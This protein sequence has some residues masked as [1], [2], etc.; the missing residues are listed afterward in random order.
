MTNEASAT[1]SG[2]AKAKVFIS[3]S[4]T[5]L[6]FAKRLD[7]TLNERGFE[8]FIDLSGIAPSELW[9]KRLKEL[10]TQADT[11]IFVLSPEAVDSK[12]CKEEV[13]YAGFPQ[14]ALRTDRL[15]ARNHVESSLR[16]E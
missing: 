9:W 12:V 2:E 4:R 5:D 13:A 1:A 3:Y 10:I 8:V 15:P 16:I 7:S 14:Q 11:V 6:E